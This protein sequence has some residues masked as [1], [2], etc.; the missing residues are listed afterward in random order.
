[1]DLNI[2]NVSLLIT[3]FVTFLYWIFNR[4]AVNRTKLYNAAAVIFGF[5][6]TIVTSLVLLIYA[7]FKQFLI[8]AS[9]DEMI[10][11]IGVVAFLVL[12]GSVYTLF[13]LVK[14]GKVEL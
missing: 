5:S 8:V 3:I 1:M 9:M 13:I 6:Y 10:D 4:H 2:F 14:K 11:T 7:I 12:L